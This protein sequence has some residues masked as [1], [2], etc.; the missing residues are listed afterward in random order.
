MGIHKSDWAHNKSVNAAIPF[1]A[2]IPSSSAGGALGGMSNSF[3]QEAIRGGE[4]NV[5]P[6]RGGPLGA[7]EEKEGRITATGK[8]S[9]TDANDPTAHAEVNAIR[10]A[11]RAL[12][13]FQLT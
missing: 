12:G 8:N 1:S 2:T 4:K 6:G 13:A 10:E 7:I 9:V 5:R 3:M 11:C